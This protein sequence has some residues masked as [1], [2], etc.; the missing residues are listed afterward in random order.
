MS[1]VEERSICSL[2]CKWS[3]SLSSQRTHLSSSCRD[4]CQAKSEAAMPR[5]VHIS[6]TPP[7]PS[8]ESWRPPALSPGPQ[9]P[10]PPRLIQNQATAPTHTTQEPL[11]MNKMSLMQ[12]HLQSPAETSPA[13]TTDLYKTSKSPFP[14]KYLK[15]LQIHLGST[16]L[17]L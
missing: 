12:Q 10:S 3:F 1:A 2:D 15:V 8:V 9:V 13:S 14:E 16:V 17:L 7:L 11:S 4:R 5:L 6:S